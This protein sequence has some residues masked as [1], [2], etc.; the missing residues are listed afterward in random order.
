MEVVELDATAVVGVQVE[1]RFGALS[2]AVPAAWRT[3]FGRRESLPPTGGDLYGEA[4][5]HLG[6]GRYRETVGVVLPPPDVPDDLAEGLV[7]VVLPAGRYVHHRHAGDVREI[8]ASFA[9][10]YD[11][12]AGNALVIGDHKL[13]LGYTADGTERSHDLYVDLSRAGGSRHEAARP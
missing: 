8:A 13:D 4:S 2:V 6:Q 10:M 7:C 3:V 12:A 1:A 11:W 9:A 5:L